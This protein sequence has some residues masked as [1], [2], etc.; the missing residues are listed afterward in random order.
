MN[1][2]ASDGPSAVL[3]ATLLGGMAGPVDAPSFPLDGRDVVLP[4]PAYV[5]PSTTNAYSVRPP[6]AWTNQKPS[7][8]L[9]SALD[10]SE[11]VIR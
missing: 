9:R 11:T 8:L 2:E 5:H 4:F 7:L 3:G 1:R 10:Q 6:N